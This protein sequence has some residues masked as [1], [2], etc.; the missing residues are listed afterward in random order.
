MRVF[1]AV[2]FPE[3]VRRYLYSLQQEVRTVCRSGHF[4]HRDNFHLTLRFLGGT[5]REE[6]Q[7]LQR[8][9]DASAQK[10]EPFFIR[11]QGLGHFLRGN[12]QILWIGIQ[13]SHALQEVYD[14]LQTE[15]S[16][17]GYPKERRPYTPHITLGR[18]VVTDRDFSDL[19]D[20]LSVEERKIPVRFLSMMQSTRVHGQLKYIPLYRAKLV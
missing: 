20:V 2:E 12:R 14:C 8:A 6:R 11:I 19:S 9:M 13:E 5:G 10:C 7:K 4:T 17:C 16:A 1:L 18:E 15:L 3:S